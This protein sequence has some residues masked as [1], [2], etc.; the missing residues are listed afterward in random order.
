MSGPNNPGYRRPVDPHDLR[1]CARLNYIGWFIN[2]LWDIPIA[3]LI[4][5]RARSFRRF[6]EVTMFVGLD[7]PF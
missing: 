7:Q 5:P 1:L 2:T 4:D 3:Q 6:M